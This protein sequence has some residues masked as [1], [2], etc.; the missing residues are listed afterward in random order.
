[1]PPVPQ[2]AQSLP[3]YPEK[4]PRQLPLTLFPLDITTPHL[5]NKGYF[6]NAIQPQVKAGSPLAR[7]CQTFLV[8]TFKKIESMLGD[9]SEPGLSLHDPL[10]IWY[11]LLRD[12]PAWAPVT[13]LE[14]I[15]VETSGQWTRGMHVVDRRV[16]N[17]PDEP[18]GSQIV[19]TDDPMDDIQL[20]EVPNNDTMGWLNVHKGNRINR[21]IASPGE[22]AFAPYLMERLFG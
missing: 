1:M 3:P 6:L 2:N 4:L 18:K 13:K 17:R 8:G 19:H 15:R 10:C 20:D 21:I 14:D 5:L 9:G 11:M 16:R 22:E 7:W 12:D